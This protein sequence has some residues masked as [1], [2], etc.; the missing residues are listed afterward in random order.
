MRAGDWMKREL[1]HISPSESVRKAWTLLREHRI[2]HLPVVDQG[3]LVGIL[4]DRDVRLVFPSALTSGAKEQDPADALEKVKVQEI[5][6][7]QVV[8]VSPD[9]PIAD[10]ARILLERRIGGL[11]IVQQGRL[12]GIITKT[13]IIA[14]FVEII[15]RKSQ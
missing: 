13:D 3:K 4:T 14:A 11:P 10:V 1:I 12:V 2:R 6:T 15:G 8:T 7:K 9:A 5:M